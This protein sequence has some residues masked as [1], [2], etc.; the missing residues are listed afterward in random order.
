VGVLLLTGPREKEDEDRSRSHTGN[1]VDDR[2]AEEDTN[3]YSN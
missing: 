2:T 3:L 1:D